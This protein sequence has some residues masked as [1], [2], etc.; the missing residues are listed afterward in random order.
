MLVPHYR[1]PPILGKGCTLPPSRLVYWLSL[2]ITKTTP[3][4]GFLGISSRDY[5]LKYPPFPRKWEYARGPIMHSSGVGGGGGAGIQ[6]NVFSK[7]IGLDNQPLFPF[8]CHRQIVIFQ[9]CRISQGLLSPQT[10]RLTPCGA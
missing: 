5:G 9:K 2:A 8:V 3:F 4:P 7:N 10:R 6:P 1:N